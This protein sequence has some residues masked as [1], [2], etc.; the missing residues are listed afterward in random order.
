MEKIKCC[1]H[2]GAKEGYRRPVGRYV[3]ELHKFTSEDKELELCMTC[4]KHYD[5]K[6]KL[7]KSRMEIGKVGFITGLKNVYKHVLHLD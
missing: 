7:I 4:F 2:C 6:K 5:R 1:G 3:V